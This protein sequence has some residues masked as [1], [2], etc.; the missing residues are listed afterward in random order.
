MRKVNLVKLIEKAK[1]SWQVLDVITINKTALRIVKI[2]GVY[3][4]HSH[5]K[6]DEF[7]LVLKG[8][9]FIDTAK[10]GSVELNEM[11]G[12]MVKKGTSHRSRS[13]KPAWVLV[14]EPAETKT[15]GE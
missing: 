1:K 2:D 8:K 14:V 13:E 9:I 11:E 6:E 3:R 12:Y 15:L 7:F 5:E 10:D 4:W